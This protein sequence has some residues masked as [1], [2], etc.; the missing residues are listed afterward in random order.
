MDGYRVTSWLVGKYI[1]I[2]LL[3]AGCAA[4]W[5]FLKSLPEKKEKFRHEQI[6]NKIK[7]EIEEKELKEKLRKEVLEEIR[8]CK[9]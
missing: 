2:P 1:F 6:K 4:A 9:K 8:S 7:K 3:I 5:A